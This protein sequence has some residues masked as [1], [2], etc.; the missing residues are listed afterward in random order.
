[1][2]I[3]ENEINFFKKN[4]LGKIYNNYFYDLKSIIDK[5]LGSKGNKPLSLYSMRNLIEMNN[6]SHY[7]YANNQLNVSSDILIK[8]HLNVLKWLDYQIDNPEDKELV[9]NEIK[10][11]FKKHFG[12][13]LKL[14]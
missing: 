6:S 1:M 3:N 4:Q 2:F 14:W 8:I 5:I 12:K 7:R 13:I 11:C 10:N 9:Q